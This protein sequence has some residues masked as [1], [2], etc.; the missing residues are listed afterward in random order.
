MVYTTRLLT[1]YLKAFSQ[2]T[3]LFIILKKKTQVKKPTME[4]V[5]CYRLVN[6]TYSMLKN[7]N[8]RYF[9]GNVIRAHKQF[10][11]ADDVLTF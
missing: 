1:H 6:D 7:R 9:N 8:I 2:C 3:A 4:N 11:D 5:S 10:V